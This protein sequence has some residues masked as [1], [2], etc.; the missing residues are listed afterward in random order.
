[1]K[2]VLDITVSLGTKRRVLWQQKTAASVLA[3]VLPLAKLTPLLS[4]LLQSK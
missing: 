3:A 2:Y 1:M 4:L